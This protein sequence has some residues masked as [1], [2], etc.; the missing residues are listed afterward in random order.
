MFQLLIRPTSDRLTRAFATN[1]HDDI[2]WN[3]KSKDEEEV[4]I[5]LFAHRIMYFYVMCLIQLFKKI[6]IANRSEVAC[7]IIQTCRRLGIKTVAIHSDV[8][9]NAVTFAFLEH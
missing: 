5:F 3:D 4:W 8:D 6:L 1:Y 7:R 2:Y 9:S